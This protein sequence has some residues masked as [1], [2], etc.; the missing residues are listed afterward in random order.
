MTQ[1]LFNI[2]FNF[3]GSPYFQLFLYR[4]EEKKYM[5]ESIFIFFL[6]KTSQN[7]QLSSSM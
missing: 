4:D 1:L 2:C 7:A 6:I 3:R 5:F